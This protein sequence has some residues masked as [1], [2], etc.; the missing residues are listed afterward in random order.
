M[1]LDVK[2]GNFRTF[3]DFTFD[4][5]RVYT[6]VGFLPKILFH[7][8]T[9][10]LNSAGDGVQEADANQR[11]GAGVSTS[12]NMACVTQADHADAF[13]DTDRS[14]SDTNFLL[15]MDAFGSISGSLELV[16]LDSDGFTLNSTLKLDVDARQG[17]LA[18]GGAD[19]TDK[20]IVVFDMKATAGDQDIT[21]IGFQPDCVIFLTVGLATAG[22][23]NSTHNEIS[24]GAAVGIA[25]ADNAVLHTASEHGLTQTN[26]RKYA[27]LGECIVTGPAS[28][29]A[30]LAARGKLTAFLSNGFRINWAE[31]DGSAMKIIA[32]ALKGGQYKI[33]GFITQT[34]TV[35]DIVVSGVGFQPKGALIFSAAQAESSA[36]S[37][38]NGCKWSVGGFNSTTS[39]F[40]ETERDRDNA[41][42]TDIAQANFA[43]GIYANIANTTA[44]L[45][46]KM[47]IKSI[48][49]DG[50][51]AIM[52]DADPTVFFCWALI[53]GDEAV[54]GEGAEII[55]A[56]SRLAFT[57]P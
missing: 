22:E 19:L 41:P 36:D 50:F 7:W 23:A 56:R 14:H 24:I 44:A 25:D 4:V 30:G 57:Q 17:Y 38:G 16:S 20:K 43:D 28:A 51:T 29:G 39:R 11:I 5:D 32:I 54:A 27:R 42:T 2:I 53:F 26:T 8:G 47:D 13:S 18:L 52:T 55:A 12:E 35:T 37:R 3:T 15:E 33:K 6:G 31:V 34:D 48:D 10:R 1:A 21:T 40:V 49:S 9:K 46:G 45:D